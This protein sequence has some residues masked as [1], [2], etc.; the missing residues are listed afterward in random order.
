MRGGP[1]VASDEVDM[2]DQVRRPQLAVDPVHR[3]PK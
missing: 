1:V 2:V 3:Y